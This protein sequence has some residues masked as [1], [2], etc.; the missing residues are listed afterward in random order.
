M[1]LARL[2]AGTAVAAVSLFGATMA[3]AVTYTYVGYWTLGDGPGWDTS[4]PVY[5]GVETAALL[6]GGSASNYVISTVDANPANINFSTWLD[7][8]GD[9][10]TYADGGTPASDTYSLDTG[11]GYNSN[12]GPDSAYSAY[13]AD[14]F[15]PAYGAQNPQFVNYAFSV[16]GAVPEPATWGLM[17][18]GVGLAGAGL[19]AARRKA[20]LTATA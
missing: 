2:L 5:S 10:Y 17:L 11:G 15:N 8:W 18:V 20:R 3:S 4:P 13:V 7:G 16:S 6:F 14:N 19:R 1:K 12:P 9:N